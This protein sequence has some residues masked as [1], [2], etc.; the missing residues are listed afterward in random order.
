MQF[1]VQIL[2]NDII[3]SNNSKV[4]LVLLKNFDYGNFTN[5]FRCV[6]TVIAFIIKFEPTGEFNFEKWI[7][8]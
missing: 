1:S 2:S 8:F 5:V 4:I 3:C 7:N 6:L